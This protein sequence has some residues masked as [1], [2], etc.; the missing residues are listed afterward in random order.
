MPAVYPAPKCKRAEPAGLPFPDAV[1]S[2]GRQRRPENKSRQ[3]I[4]RVYLPRLAAFGA[5][6]AAAG[7]P[8]TIEG[9]RRE[10]I[11]TYILYLQRRG[12]RTQGEHPP[13]TD[14]GDGVHRVPNVARVLL[15]DGA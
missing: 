10:H 1:Q 7:V 15:L 8:Q 3:T 2:F 11:E 6:L 12:A 4:E 9:I 5:W 14:A 13:G